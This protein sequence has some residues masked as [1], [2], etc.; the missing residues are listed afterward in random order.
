MPTLMPTPCRKILSLVIAQLKH[1][2]HMLMI[3]QT[4]TVF[5]ES[6]RDVVLLWMKAC[7]LPAVTTR[8]FVPR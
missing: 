4:P 6:L 8:V 2:L 1:A 7:C 3:A 5:K